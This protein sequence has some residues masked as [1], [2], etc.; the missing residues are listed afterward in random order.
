MT[1]RVSY[2]PAFDDFANYRF[3]HESYIELPL[4]LGWWKLRL[5]VS[6]DSNCKP[7]AGPERGD[8]TFFTRVV[9]NWK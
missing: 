5:G 8:T 9:R 3:Y 2:V 1:N 4:K 7:T 6:N